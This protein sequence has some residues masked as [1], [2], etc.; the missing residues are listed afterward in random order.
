MT[1][2]VIAVS[3]L[4]KAYGDKTVLDGIDLDVSRGHGPSPCSARTGAGK[5]DDGERADHVDKGRQ[6]DGYGWPGTTSRTRAD[7]VRARSSGSPVKFA[8]GGR[9]ADRGREPAADGGSA[10][11][12]GRRGQAGGH[13]GCWKR[14]RSGRKS[15]QKDGRRPISGRYCGPEAGSG[16]DTGHQA[17]DHFPGRAVRRGLDPRSRRTMWGTSSAS[18]VAE[19]GRDGFSSPPKLSRKKPISSPAGSRYSTR[20][21]WSPRALPTSSSAR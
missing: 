18:W 5:N 1:S 8:A 21:T 10:P 12:A 2:S 20:A 6:R 3:G 7:A 11:S 16:D 4:R 19:T 14:F 17:T 15:A 9:S 13:L